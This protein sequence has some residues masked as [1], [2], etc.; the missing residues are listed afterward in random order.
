MRAKL[1]PSVPSG[2]AEALAGNRHY[3]RGTTTVVRALDVVVV[4]ILTRMIKSVS[5]DRLQS[6]WS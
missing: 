1:S 3:Y 5:Q 2:F 6:L 4:L